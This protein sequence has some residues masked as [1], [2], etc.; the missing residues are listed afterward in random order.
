MEAAESPGTTTVDLE[1][2]IFNV[3]AI[4]LFSP[5]YA[6]KHEDDRCIMAWLVCLLACVVTIVQWSCLSAL[7]YLIIRSNS[8]NLEVSW[9]P[10]VAWV[11]LWCAWAFFGTVVLIIGKETFRAFLE[12]VFIESKLRP[13]DDNST[14]LKL[15]P[16]RVVVFVSKII[17]YNPVVLSVFG[18]FLYF[19]VFCLFSNVDGSE[20]EYFNLVL[21]LLAFV[22]I[23]EM[24]DWAYECFRFLWIAGEAFHPD[25]LTVEN[26]LSHSVTDWK[27]VVYIAS[28]NFIFLGICAL[29]ALGFWFTLT[30]ITYCVV[31]GIYSLF[32][33]PAVVFFG[34]KFRFGRNLGVWASLLWSSLLYSAGAFVGIFT[35]RDEPI[36]FWVFVILWIVF[37]LFT[38]GL[39]WKWCTCCGCCIFDSNSEVTETVENMAEA[40]QAVHTEEDKEI[41]LVIDEAQP[42]V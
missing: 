13:W 33:L 34:V 12:T 18:S 40:D 31:V 3:A 9:F 15:D 6:A 16:P 19:T 1:P 38:M 28:F 41:E 42:E 36:F 35:F 17:V 5:A 20:S 39:F 27:S 37:L 22:F 25:D 26:P 29:L 4:V 8:S 7:M 32:F 30:R 2:N 24:D 21:N 10:K 14:F 23:F 11:N